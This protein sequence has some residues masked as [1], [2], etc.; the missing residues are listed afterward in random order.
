MKS[1]KTIH[2]CIHKIILSVHK[3]ASFH[4][5]CDLEWCHQWNCIY[6]ICHI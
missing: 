3:L 5:T 6:P 2:S 1:H 4:S